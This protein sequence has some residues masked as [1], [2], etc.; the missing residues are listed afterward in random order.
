MVKFDIVDNVVHV[1]FDVDV[2]PGTDQASVLIDQEGT[3]DQAHDRFVEQF[4]CL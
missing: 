3:A 1:G 2:A 4:F